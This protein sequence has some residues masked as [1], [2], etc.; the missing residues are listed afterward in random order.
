MTVDKLLLILSDEVTSASTGLALDGQ[1]ATGGGL[2]SGNH[3]PGGDFQFRINVLTGDAD[4][5]GTISLNDL[6]TLATSW[7]QPTTPANLFADWAD[8]FEEMPDRFIVGVD[9]KFGRNQRRYPLGRYGEEVERI[10]RLL[11]SLKP[12]A[13]RRIG[14]DNAARMFGD[15]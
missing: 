10:R 5:N 1:Y 14:H 2:P 4:R 7:Q 6:Q 12:A 9:A 3:V 11:G 13:A 15:K 8:L